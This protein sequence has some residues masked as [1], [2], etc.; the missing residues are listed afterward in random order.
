MTTISITQ[1][2]S[3]MMALISAPDESSLQRAM[4]D[5][6]RRFAEYCPMAMDQPRQDMTQRWSV[7][8]R[9]T[10]EMF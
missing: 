7:V 4:R 9:P 6:Q 8:M 3:D 1:T 2:D 5:V 10:V